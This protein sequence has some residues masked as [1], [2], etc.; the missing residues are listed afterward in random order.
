M[1]PRL[2]AIP[3]ALLA[4]AGCADDAPDAA[5]ATEAVAPV[6]EVTIGATEAAAPVAQVTIERSRF[7]ETNLTVSPG[8][9]V[10]FVNADPFDHTVTAR[11]DAPVAFDSG[12]MA[13][14]DVFEV[15]F[16]RVGTYRYFCEIHP[17]MRATVVVA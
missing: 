10:R 17:T 16:D 2:I 14:D 11:D 3:I 6:V 13:Q 12:T 8:T 9:T 4:L 1:T 7:S 5:G 15:T